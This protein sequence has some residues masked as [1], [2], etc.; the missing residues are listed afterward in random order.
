[1]VILHSIP[2]KNNWSKNWWNYLVNMYHQH[3]MKIKGKRGALQVNTISIQETRAEWIADKT[4]LTKVAILRTIWCNNWSKNNSNLF[5]WMMP[6]MS[7]QL[8]VNT[9]LITLLD[10]LKPNILGDFTKYKCVH[11]KYDFTFTIIRSRSL[12]IY[13]YSPFF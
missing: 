7:K 11:S 13:I 10:H 1:M 5:S 3:M 4:I 9:T 8:F 12:Q 6:I 2:C